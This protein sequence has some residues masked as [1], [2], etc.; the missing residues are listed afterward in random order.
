MTTIRDVLFGEVIPGQ[1]G[2][3]ARKIEEAGEKL[4]K[5]G[6]IPRQR[7]VPAIAFARA[8]M[9]KVADLLNL[10][11]S[12]LLV[13]AWRLRSALLKAGH[14]TAA[15]PGTYKQVP[16]KSYAFP[17]DHELDV[18][19]TWNSAAIA[20]VTFVVTVTVEVTAVSAVVHS[21]HLTSI[22]GGEGVVRAALRVKA[23]GAGV[24][25]AKGD[26]HFD[27][28]MEM[29]LAGEGIPLVRE[30]PKAHHPA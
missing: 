21:G 25:L 2:T 22:H 18:D 3:V 23:R 28:A 4:A 27:L 19:V 26:R 30:A 6:A 29:K 1:A 24:P 20:T 15:N 17:W 11:V 13:E 8:V 7:E 14:E 9:T 10:E 16:I 5:V 12:G